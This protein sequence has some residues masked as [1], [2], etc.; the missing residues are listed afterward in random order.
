MKRLIMPSDRAVSRKTFVSRALSLSAAAAVIGPLVYV[1]VTLLHPGGVGNDHPA[2]FRHYAM[3]QTWVVIHLVQLAALVVGLVGIAGLAAFMLRLQDNCR[4][5][6]LLAVGLAAASIPIAVALQV[7]DGIALKRAVDVWI[8]EGGTVGSPSFAAARAIRWLEEGFNAGF[9]LTLGLAVILV[10]AAMARGA[11]YPRLL[12][13]IGGAIGI[14]VL[15]GAIIVAETGF[16][17]TAQTWVL[18]RNPALWI[19]TA[20]AGVLMWRRLRSLDATLPTSS[21]GSDQ[22]PGPAR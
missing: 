13:W 11:V 14:A 20:V 9:G 4:V 10:G 5:L 1:A 15:I 8:A 6:A 17:P 19:W 2:I 3:S 7:I 21:P 22:E 12:G 16:S 18:A